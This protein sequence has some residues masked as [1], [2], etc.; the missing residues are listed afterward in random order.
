[1]RKGI[2]APRAARYFGA[3]GGAVQELDPTRQTTQAMDNGWYED[4]AARAVDVVGFNY[5]TDKIA[6]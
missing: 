2:R 4:G 6:F 3:A 1:M 5:R